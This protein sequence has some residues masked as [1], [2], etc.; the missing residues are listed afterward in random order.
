MIPVHF[1]RI[2]V[3][4]GRNGLLLGENADAKKYHVTIVVQDN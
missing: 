2:V 1:Q 3:G 4:V